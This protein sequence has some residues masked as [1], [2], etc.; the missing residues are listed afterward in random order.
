[1]KESLFLG[2]DEMLDSLN[3]SDELTEGTEIEEVKTFTVP[4]DGEGQRLDV[5][6]TGLL[7]G[8]RS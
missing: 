2:D 8:S 3:E 6:L 5:F 7:E 1:M 4:E